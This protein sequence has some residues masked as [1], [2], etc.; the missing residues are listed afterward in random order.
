M[1]DT[2]AIRT[3]TP[4]Q[5]RVLD[6]D[7]FHNRD[8]QLSFALFDRLR[9]VSCSSTKARNSWC[10]QVMKTSLLCALLMLLVGTGCSGRPDALQ[11]DF[12]PSR[13]A[14]HAL[15][16][17][18]TDS[19]GQIGGNELESV[20]AIKK[21]LS[22]YDSD[23]DGSVSED[24]L[25]AR[26]ETWEEA[27]VAFRRLDVK[28]T[29]DGR[30]LPNA[31]IIFE[32]EV[33]MSEWVKPA[34]GTTDKA[35]MA[36]VSVAPDDLPAEIKQRGLNLQGVYVGAYKVKIEHPGSKLPDKFRNGTTLGEDTSRDALDVS[37]HIDIRTRS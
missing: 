31:K 37:T 18:D 22:L 17:Y 1:A 10:N 33:Y 12:A 9:D 29:L 23:G 25:E 21:N 26:F 24:E 13:T 27:G 30:P 20:P 5:L 19:D 7:K 3:R 11:T 15:A 2:T 32:P 6:S 8:C 16:T 14:S 4:S 35:G 28:L 36:K 34:T